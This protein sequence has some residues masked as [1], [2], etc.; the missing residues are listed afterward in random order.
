[1]EIINSLWVEKYRPKVIQD[2]VIPEQYQDDFNEY[3]SKKDIP[4]LLLYGPPGG[5][6]T[7]IARI[8]SSPTGILNN[9][10][11][12][13]LELNGS[14]KETRGINFVS[15]VIEPFLKIPSSDDKLKIVFIDESDHLTDA[16][17]HSLRSIIEKYSQT[18]RFIFTCN[19]V[20]KIP[21][22]LKS[23]LS[24]YKFKEVP[25]KF[26]LDYCKKILNNENISFDENDLKFIIDGLY[27]DI[28]KIVSKIQ[29]LSISNKLKVN[30]NIELT[31]ENTIISCTV[32]IIS[33]IQSGEKQKIGKNLNTIINILSDFEIDYSDIYYK[34]FFREEIPPNVKIKINEYSSKHNS[35]LV[36]KMNFLAMIFESINIL[37]EYNRINK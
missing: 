16:S 25:I 21:D 37:R 34:L 9:P 24:D 13:L 11:D 2:M 27:P 17:F 35:C 36:P 12:N 18:S 23:R 6:K 10:E 26:V 30:K 3:I 7:T 1:M 22:A 29:K 31:N 5:G 4:S 19:Y 15:E 33:I 32:E 28:R 20:S 8:I 14:A